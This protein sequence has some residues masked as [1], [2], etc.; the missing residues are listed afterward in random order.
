MGLAPLRAQDDK[1]SMTGYLQHRLMSLQHDF[2]Q[3]PVWSFWSLDRLIKNDLY[4]K[5]QRRLRKANPTACLD[6]SV[7]VI[8]GSRKRA[9]SAV[10]LDDPSVQTEGAKQDNYE[11]LFGRVDPKDIPESGGWW[12][13]QQ[14]ELMA[15]S[16]DHEMGLMTE[17]V[18][19][20]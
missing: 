16:D 19:I 2:R 17:M 18:T 9:A 3:P 13:N 6:G 1:V 12:K 7:S 11:M 10:G 15:I 8:G 4:F 5:H 14:T 20:T